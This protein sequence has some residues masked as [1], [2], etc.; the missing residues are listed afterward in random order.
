MDHPKAVERELPQGLDGE[1]AIEWSYTWGSYSPSTE[2]DA[3]RTRVGLGLGRTSDRI[4][5]LRA[6]R[7]FDMPE[8]DGPQRFFDSFR[9]LP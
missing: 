6:S 3:E 8:S 7:D 2:Q 4:Y 9:L 5:M 1:P